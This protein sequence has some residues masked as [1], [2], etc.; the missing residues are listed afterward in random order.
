M[1]PMPEQSAIT[2]DVSRSMVPHS[3]KKRALVVVAVI[4]LIVGAFVAT[5]FFVPS[6]RASVDEAT[7]IL[8]LPHDLRAAT[9]I[10]SPND[11]RYLD[12]RTADSESYDISEW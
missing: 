11:Q 8:F 10:T 5:Y 7:A 4:V 1:E 6:V 12:E 2:P 9:F 3:R